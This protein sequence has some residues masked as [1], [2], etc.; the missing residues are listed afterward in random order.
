MGAYG[1]LL[2]LL[3]ALKN[4]YLAFRAVARQTYFMAVSLVTMASCARLHLLSRHMLNGVGQCYQLLMSWT[5]SFPIKGSDD[6]SYS[7]LPPSLEA[8]LFDASSGVSMAEST[9]A[10]DEMCHSETQPSESHRP[11][12]ME[13]EQAATV[14]DEFWSAGIGDTTDIDMAS[15]AVGEDHSADGSLVDNPST[16]AYNQESEP[17]AGDD[18]CESHRP[19]VRGVK[20]S[21]TADIR[22]PSAVSR[23]PGPTKRSQLAKGDAS[24]NERTTNGIV[25]PNQATEV[26][27]KKQLEKNQ[28]ENLAQER[29]LDRNT[30]GSAFLQRKRKAATITVAGDV[31]GPKDAETAD[32]QSH[33]KRMN[34]KLPKKKKNEIDEIFGLF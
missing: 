9:G 28:S 15:V 33:K 6:S 19:N 10:L 32:V 34:K 13:I 26:A 12:L 7:K 23:V 1:L 2:R 8:S 20:N 11:I 17:T 14:S 29:N 18:S 16:D 5:Q 21:I 22:M 31:L 3:I 4:T 24:I 27:N 30:T 25:L